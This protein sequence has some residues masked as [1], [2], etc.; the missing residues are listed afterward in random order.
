M[1]DQ[2]LD[3]DPL[4]QVTVLNP[5]VLPGNIRNMR[6]N[7]DSAETS[8]QSQSH[9]SPV[10]YQTQA[11]TSTPTDNFFSDEGKSAIFSKPTSPID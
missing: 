2:E 8:K 10:N 3:I 5:A 9:A 11:N 7:Q 6:F 4:S 1:S